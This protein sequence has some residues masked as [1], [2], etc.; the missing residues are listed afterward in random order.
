MILDMLACD[1]DRTALVAM[2]GAEA[3]S[4]KRKA[5]GD[6]QL[7]TTTKTKE[8]QVYRAVK[9]SFRY[10]TPANGCMS[11][12]WCANSITVCTKSTFWVSKLDGVVESRFMTREVHAE[13][14][15]SVYSNTTAKTRAKDVGDI[16]ISDGAAEENQALFS[17]YVGLMTWI[18]DLTKTDR[19][20]NQAVPRRVSVLF[21]M[22]MVQKGTSI[23]DK[24]YEY[25]LRDMYV[26]SIGL[27]DSSAIQLW[28]RITKIQVPTMVN[29]VNVNINNLWA[30]GDT[31]SRIQSAF[32]STPRFICDYIKTGGCMTNIMESVEGAGRHADVADINNS[33]QQSSYPNR[34][35]VTGPPVLVKEIQSCSKKIKR[36]KG[37]KGVS[38][39]PVQVEPV[40]R[41]VSATVDIVNAPVT[42]RAVV[43]V[44]LRGGTH[45]KEALIA[46]ITNYLADKDFARRSVIMRTFMSTVGVGMFPSSNTLAGYLHHLQRDGHLQSAGIGH[47][48]RNYHLVYLM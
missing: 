32:D 29:G 40:P 27:H 33:Y 31:I 23:C 5:E 2:S 39:S 17:S 30:Q 37:R 4:R 1:V 19:H 16:V 11:I 38:V 7:E 13:G 28:G 34:L 8:Q 9:T 14:D 26:R 12:A 25:L 43:P 22:D 42:R 21:A 44:E 47:E 15:A 45:R 24:F 41:F 20:L 36:A 35:R 18:R 48:K 6:L 3:G 10:G 46:F